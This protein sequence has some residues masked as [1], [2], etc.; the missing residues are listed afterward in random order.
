[1]ITRKL[2]KKQPKSY[3]EGI[4]DPQSQVL[5]VHRRNK[6]FGEITEKDEEGN[7]FTREVNI[8]SWRQGDYVPLTK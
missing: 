6:Y 2:D 4:K 3:I 8:S 5:W 1:M 7:E